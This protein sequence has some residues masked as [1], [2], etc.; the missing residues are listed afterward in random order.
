MTPSATPMILIYARVARQAVQEGKPLAATGWFASGYLLSWTA[1]SFLA[2]IAQGALV[3]VAWLTPTMAA[4]STKVGGVV[5]I[6][7]GV[8]QFTPLKNSCLRQC[9]SPFAFIQANGGFRRGTG[10]SIHSGCVTAFTA[11]AAAGR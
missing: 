6:V 9:Q 5:L 1:F 11:S 8:Y 7:A 3:R 2:A 4:A 10:A